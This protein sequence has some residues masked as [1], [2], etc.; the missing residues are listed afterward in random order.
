MWQSTAKA[1]FDRDL[2]LAV[3]D[4]A[5][6]VHALVFPCRRVIFGWANSATGAYVHVHPTHWR[7]WAG[8]VED[9]PIGEPESDRLAIVE[10]YADDPRAIIK[11]DRDGPN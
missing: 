2:E 1:P 6:D 7:E 9:A 4:A 8:A 10:K 3:I 5:G 11:K